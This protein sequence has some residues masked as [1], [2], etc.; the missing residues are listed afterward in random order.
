MAT[1]ALSTNRASA[2]GGQDILRTLELSHP[3]WR[4]G[5]GKPVTY[6]LTDW[7]QEF[8]A[9]LESGDTVT[10]TPYPFAVVLPTLDGA[11][12]QEMQVSLTNADLMVGDLVR[13]AHVDPSQRIECVYREFLSDA[14]DAPQSAPLRLSFDMI[15][16]GDDAVTGVAGR[17]DVLNRRFPSVWY[18]VQHFPGLDR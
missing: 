3:L 15:Q 2:V 5:A 7:P 16:I 14:L 6:Y 4:D 12:R 8:D 13:A 9:V 17:S 1:T 10:F 11:G 18:D